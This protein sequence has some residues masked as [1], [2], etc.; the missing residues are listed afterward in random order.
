MRYLALLLTMA[1]AFAGTAQSEYP[2]N[3]DDNNDG[4]IGLVDLLGLLTL[5]DLIS[6]QKSFHS[7]TRQR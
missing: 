2:Y 6:P 4:Y 5:F 7:M 3:P 1:F